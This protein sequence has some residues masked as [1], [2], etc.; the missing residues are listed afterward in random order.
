MSVTGRH[1]RGL[2]RVVT[3]AVSYLT[4]AAVVTVPVTLSAQA[5]AA[6]TPPPLKVVTFNTCGQSTCQSKQNLATWASDLS[7]SIL[8]Y[9]PDVVGI[10]E[11]CGNQVGALAADLPGYTADFNEANQLNPGNGCDHWDAAGTSEPATALEFGDLI[12]VKA[13]ESPV[14]HNDVIYA[15]DPTKGYGPLECA[16]ATDTGVAYQ[17]CDVHLGGGLGGLNSQGLPEVINRM[18]F[19]GGANTPTV[20]AGDFNADPTDP[21]LGL[22]YQAQDGNGQFVEAE[23]YDKAY[24]TPQCQQL[25][26]CRSG[27][28]TTLPAMSGGVVASGGEARKFDYIFASAKDFTVDSDAIV[29]VKAAD[30]SDLTVNDHL[31]YQATLDWYAAGDPTPAPSAPVVFANPS[32]LDTDQWGNAVDYTA[33]NF[34]GTGKADM[35][36]RYADGTVML[37]PPGSTTG[38]FGAGQQLKPTTQGW[39]DAAS[40]T[41]GDFDGDGANDGRSD[42]LVRWNR[43]SVFLYPNNGAGGL[44]GSVSLLPVDSWSSAVSVG[45]GHVL[46]STDTAVNDAVVMSE[47]RPTPYSS[48]PTFTVSAYPVYRS[49]TGTYSVGAAVPLDL[50]GATSLSDVVDM[51]VGDFTG[52]GHAEILLRNV[53]GTLALY[54]DNAQGNF[55]AAPLTVTDNRNWSSLTDGPTPSWEAVQ[56]IAAGD[57]DGSGKDGV[58]LVWGNEYQGKL[59]PGQGQTEYLASTGTAPGALFAAPAVITS[60]SIEKWTGEADFLAATT[61]SSGDTD[62]ITRQEGSPAVG[63]NPASPGLT[64]IWLG[65]GTG[66]FGGQ[67]LASAGYLDWATALAVGGFGAGGAQELFAYNGSAAGFYKLDGTTAQGPPTTQISGLQSVDWA[68]VAEVIPGTFYGG[69]YCDLVIRYSDGSVLLYQNITGQNGSSPSVPQFAAP[70]QLKPPGSAGWGDAV[71]ISAGD[72]NG[73]GNEDLL[74]RWTAGSLFLYPGDGAGH[75]G[76]TV[77]ITSAPAMADLR[78]IDQGTF[79]GAAGGLHNMYL[80]ADGE[81]VIDT[82]SANLVDP[83]TPGVSGTSADFL[84]HADD[85]TGGIQSFSYQ[86]DGGPAI[87][88]DAFHNEVNAQLQGLTPGSHTLTVTATNL[89]GVTSTAT[90]YAFTD[91][92]S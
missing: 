28:P 38:T 64:D 8:A 32:V 30:G 80:F 3:L 71:Q 57:F 10:Q 27:M 62:L 83:A 76:G 85:Y 12:F 9:G 29:E 39:Y 86:L 58:V 25:T 33:G 77:I 15:T 13:S 63:D 84:L 47:S 82:G 88:L 46:G 72:F 34:T 40:M 54:G 56:S 6:A 50:G 74:V 92:S 18:Q 16:E 37:Y 67:E 24:F 23:Q 35:V 61:T 26:S 87:S 43:G 65:R 70:T 1:K 75:L 60:G 21:H 90:T 17:Y 22:L 91:T 78:S 79:F 59:A 20:L 41:A 81:S 52:I 31:M 42:L 44:G 48:A 11:V 51:T 68:D 7:A 55:A 66:T 69:P 2:R 45:A 53:N 14:F 49:A 4:A 36:V 5:A 19:W 73:D 89:A